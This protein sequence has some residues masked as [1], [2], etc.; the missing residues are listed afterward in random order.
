MGLQL[1]EIVNHEHDA[2]L[3]NGGLG[4]L[5]ACFLDC[6]ANL[7]LL[8]RDYGIR[9]EY[10]KLNCFQLN[11]THPA[12]AVPELMRLLMDKHGLLISTKFGQQRLV[13][14]RP[15]DSTIRGRDLERSTDG[16]AVD[17]KV[18]GHPHSWLWAVFVNSNIK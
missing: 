14:K 5:A 15:N 9:Y 13:L 4:R 1:E 18:G 2:G 17:Q 3:G 11:N 12:T 10:G 8:V 16:R 6:C 7:G